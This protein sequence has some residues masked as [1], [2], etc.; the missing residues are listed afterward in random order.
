[1]NAETA[2]PL[3]MLFAFAVVL[4]FIYTVDGLTEGGLVRFAIRYLDRMANA[5]RRWSNDHR[6]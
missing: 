4:L 6:R 3:D 5:L 2:T 1:M